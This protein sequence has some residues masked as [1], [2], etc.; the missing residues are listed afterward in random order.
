[1]IV[2]RNAYKT[3]PKGIGSRSERPLANSRRLHRI[4]PVAEIACERI[5]R[6]VQIYGLLPTPYFR[7]KTLTF[8]H[9]F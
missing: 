6:V 5:H 2:A 3:S 8:H 1:M 4:A 7:Q 9:Q